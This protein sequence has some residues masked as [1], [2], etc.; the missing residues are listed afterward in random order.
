MN[1][2]LKKGFFPFPSDLQIHILQNALLSFNRIRLEDYTR[3]TV[4]GIRV[5]TSVFVDFRS[6][7]FV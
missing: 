1:T 7:G 4:D 6:D 5:Y 2:I 3:T